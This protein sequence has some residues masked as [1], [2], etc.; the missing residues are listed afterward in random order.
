LLLADPSNRKAA[1]ATLSPGER[2]WGLQGTRMSSSGQDRATPELQ[3]LPEPG[4]L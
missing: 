4:A 2:L 1:A 3:S